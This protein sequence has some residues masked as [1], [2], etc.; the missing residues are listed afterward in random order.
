MF[1]AGIM[2]SLKS[3]IDVFHQMLTFT[4]RNALFHVC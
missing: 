4:E 2:D 1:R 3:G